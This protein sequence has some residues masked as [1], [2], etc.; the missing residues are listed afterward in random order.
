VDG[1]S[2]TQHYEGLTLTAKPDTGGTWEIGY[3]HNAPDIG[4]ST[5]W[6][7]EQAQ[8]QF[9][10]DYAKAVY[11][12]IRDLG[13]NEWCALDAVRRSIIND[14][15]FEM[16]EEGLAAFHDF[17]AAVKAGDWPKAKA[18][19]LDSKWAREVST[20][21]NENAEMMLSGAWSSDLPGITV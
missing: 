14:M 4:P 15:S 10:V 9:S 8:N 2:L 17:L 13:Y 5:V 3:G 21:A 6:T 16:G 18:S 1:P 11:G 20:R 12:A 7:L 19:M